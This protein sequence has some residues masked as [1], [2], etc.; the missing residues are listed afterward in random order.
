VKREEP[1]K[2]HHCGTVG[3]SASTHTHFLGGGVLFCIID[4]HASTHTP[5]SLY[6]TLTVREDEEGGAGLLCLL[7]Q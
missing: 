4:I 3:I 1:A 5:P 6:L 7:L 2:L